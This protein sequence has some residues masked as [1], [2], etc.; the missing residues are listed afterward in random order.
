MIGP[1]TIVS[2]GSIGS[3]TR[4]IEAVTGVGVARPVWLRASATSTRR[5]S[6][7]GWSPAGVVDALQKVL[8]RQR[9]ADK[10]LQR[11]RASA[12]QQDA[13]RLAPSWPTMASVVHRQDGFAPDAAAGPGPGHP[14]PGGR[15]VVVAGSPD[16]AKVAVAV[17]S[18]DEAVDA[19]ATVKMLAHMVG[20]GG[21]GIGRAG[22]GRRRR[23]LEDRRPAGRGGAGSAPELGAGGL[24]PVRVVGIDLG[25]APHRRGRLR[26]HRHPGVAALHRRAQRERRRRLA[27]GGRWS[28]RS[29]ARRVVVGLP[30]SLDGRRGPAARAAQAEADQLAQTLE[31]LGVAVETFDERLTTVSAERSLAEAG[32][33]R[34]QPAH[35]VDQAA[36]AVMLQAWLDAHP[37]RGDA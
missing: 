26:R 9:Q 31:P 15:V 19:G 3:N 35:V 28:R 13:A 14:A 29:G 32:R 37:G 16:G 23:P 5:P 12:L 2:E 27:R 24:R 34:A 30:L 6:C 1:I 25:D 18:G 8:D 17:A 33:R 4:R 7:C 21:R 36:A 10:E 22:R 11:L 20:G